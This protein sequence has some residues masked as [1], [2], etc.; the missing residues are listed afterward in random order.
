LTS[1]QIFF[2]NGTEITQV[3]ESPIFI[4]D[5]KLSGS[6]IVW[7]T[8]DGLYL[9]NGGD[10]VELASSSDQTFYFNL[11]DVCGPYVAWHLWQDYDRIYFYNG[12]DTVQITEPGIQCDSMFMMSNENIAW[13]Q[14]IQAQPPQVYFWNGHVAT[15]LDPDVSGASTLILMGVSGKNVAWYADGAIFLS[16][17]IPESCQE[18]LAMGYSIASDLNRD[19]KVNLSDVAILSEDWLRSFD[20]ADASHEMPWA[21]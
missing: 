6:N 7:S 18:A 13:I 4:N 8:S 21:D 3:T 10:I 2:W 19:C 1:Q 15:Q 12:T 14:H 11:F 17:Q 16:R 20:P 5:L 9:W